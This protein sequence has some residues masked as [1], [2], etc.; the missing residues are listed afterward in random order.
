MLVH[1]IWLAV[2]TGMNE[3]EKVAVLEHFSDPEKVFYASEKAYRSLEGISPNAVQ[4]LLDKDLSESQQILRRCT[5]E[6]IHIC[7]Y[8]DGA[9]PTRL[10]NIADPPLVLYCKG[11]LPDLNEQPVI[12]VVG[13]RKFSAYGISAAKRMGYQIARCGAVVVSGAA[14]GIDSAAMT[15]ALTGGGTVIGVLGCGVDVVYP[16]SNHSLYQ[17]VQLQGCLVS[18]F[19]PGTPP[20][21]WNFP[22]RNRI[23]SGLSCGVLVVEAPENSGALITARRAAEQGRDVFVVPGNIDMPSFMGSNA[24]L[25]DGAIMAGCGWDVVGEYRA[26]YP[27]KVH[28]DSMPYREEE[29]FVPKVAQKPNSPA[30]TETFDRKKEKITIDKGS[31]CAYS[32][33]VGEYT[34]ASPE[35]KLLLDSLG[36]DTRLVD[37]L[38]AETGL[39]AGK[40]LGMLTMLEL[41][42]VLERLPGK[43]IKRKNKP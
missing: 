41:K 10:K 5:D 39:S 13:T 19:P 14:K 33:V 31:T 23:I 20:L 18:E 32:D 8:Y 35:E 3:R 34:P 24:L 29:R 40:M 26:L 15:G 30:K 2:K 11:V 12:A 42:G 7:T 25:R 21:K 6:R 17:D 9:Y 43:Q 4:A 38:I 16:A 1:W 37:E 27:D 28:K 36:T 22:K